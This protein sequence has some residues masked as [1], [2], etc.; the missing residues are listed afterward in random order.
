M[1]EGRSLNN[2]I[3]FNK[4]NFILLKHGCDACMMP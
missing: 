2:K 3:G 1:K 4:N